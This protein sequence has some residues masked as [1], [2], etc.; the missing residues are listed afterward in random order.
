MFYSYSLFIDVQIFMLIE[1]QTHI[2]LVNTE[3]CSIIDK[4]AETESYCY[5]VRFCMT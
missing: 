1:S 3:L 5:A 2:A 4:P